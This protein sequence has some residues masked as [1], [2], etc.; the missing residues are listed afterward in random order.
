MAGRCSLGGNVKTDFDGESG[1]MCG[2]TK[3]S[4]A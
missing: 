3:S 4:N 2:E 1:R